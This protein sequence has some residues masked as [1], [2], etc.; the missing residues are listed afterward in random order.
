MR[1]QDAVAVLGVDFAAGGN[2]DR[3]AVAIDA[4]EMDTVAEV[5]VV[6][7]LHRR[8]VEE[9]LPAEYG[10]ADACGRR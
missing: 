3:L 7:H 8:T 2:A 5:I 4:D 1:A 10:L 9:R 6:A